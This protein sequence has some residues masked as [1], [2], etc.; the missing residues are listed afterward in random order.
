MRA[1]NVTGSVNAPVPAFASPFPSGTD[2]CQSTSTC[3][4]NVA[5]SLLRLGTVLRPCATFDV[6]I[7]STLLSGDSQLHR[8]PDEAE[9]DPRN[10]NQPIAWRGRG[11]I[12][13]PHVSA[14]GR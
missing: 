9:R 10:G 12:D 8:G 13:N 7:A 5:M 3:R 14:G 2:P 1:G 4:S 11:W 6:K